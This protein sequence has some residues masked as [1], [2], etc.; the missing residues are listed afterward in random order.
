MKQK[1]L[2]LIFL[3]VI[4]V[5]LILFIQNGRKSNGKNNLNPNKLS[6]NINQVKEKI[7]ILL[8]LIQILILIQ[9]Q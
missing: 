8:K 7:W 9:K 5:L 6:E 3:L 4:V 2:M 1:L